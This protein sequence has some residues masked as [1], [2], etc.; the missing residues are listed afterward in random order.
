[1][2]WKERIKEYV[3]YALYNYGV[4]TYIRCFGTHDRRKQKHRVALCLIFKNEAPFLKE[5]LDFHLALG[6]DHFYLYNN[7]SDDDFREVLRPYVLGGVITLI[8]WPQP[9]SQ[10]WAYKDCYTRF[11]SEC[12]WIGFLDADEFVCPKYET[13]INDW[14]RRFDRF[15]SVMISYL[16]FGTGGRV[17]HDYGKDVIE[18]YHVCSRN[19]A[20]YGKCFVN[21]RFEVHE[22]EWENQYFLHHFYMLYPIFGRQLRTPPVDQFGRMHRFNSPFLTGIPKQRANIY[23]NHY[24]TKAWN[25]YKGKIKRGDAWYASNPR[26]DYQYFFQTEDENTEV[27]YTICRF[28]I[29]MKLQ[30]GTIK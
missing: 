7:N 26:E 30:K 23:V 24:W 13:D 14:L 17:E 11:R 8:D 3:A 19:L 25:L 18:Q 22:Q 15:P 2:K 9:H 1:M 16:M 6:V 21:T 4:R 10:R 12:N 29:R 27:D 20:P 28:L 5:W